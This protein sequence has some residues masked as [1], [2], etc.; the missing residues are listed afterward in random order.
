MGRRLVFLGVLLMGSCT[1]KPVQA[2][3]EDVPRF[4]GLPP[5][6]HNH[7]FVCLDDASAPRLQTCMR[8]DVLKGLMHSVRA[9]E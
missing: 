5:E 4:Y 8:I 1:P 6:I 9:E 2:P 7:D 3:A